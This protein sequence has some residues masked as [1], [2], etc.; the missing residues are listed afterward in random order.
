VV[1]IDQRARALKPRE[2]SPRV[3]DGTNDE[4]GFAEERAAACGGAVA[5]HNGVVAA[6]VFAPE[7]AKYSFVSCSEVEVSFFLFE[8]VTGLRNAAENMRLKTM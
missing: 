1:P 5:D 3:R 2:K 8:G 4:R 6:C 7:R